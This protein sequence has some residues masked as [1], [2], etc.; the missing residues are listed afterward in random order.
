MALPA[1]RLGDMST[2]SLSMAALGESR[3]SEAAAASIAGHAAASSQQRPLPGS[4]LW[5]AAHSSAVTGS[6][7]GTPFHVRQAFARILAGRGWAV[8]L[9]RGHLWTLIWVAMGATAVYLL[10]PQV[11][12]LQESLA[13]L[14]RVQLGW[15]AAGA[16]LVVLRYLLAAL[17]LHAAV[18]RPLPFGLRCSCRSPAPSSAASRPR[19]SA[20]RC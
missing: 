3:G 10:L 8:R 4:G 9:R 18:G 11:A 13:S 6:N 1:A 7:Q 2:N 12:E 5:A 15:L 16:S 14:E 20:G 19:A 17:S